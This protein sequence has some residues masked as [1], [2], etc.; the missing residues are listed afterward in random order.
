LWAGYLGFLPLLR[1]RPQL[2]WPLLPLLVAMTYVNFCSGDWW[3]GGSF[4]NRR[5][6]SLLPLLALGFAASIDWARERVAMRPE[7]VLVL[8]AVPLVT[9][10]VLLA[11]QLRRGFLPRD[12]T[13]AFPRLVTG[14]AQLFADGFGSPQT[15]P[16]S[17]IFAWRHG[18]SPGRYDLVVG[19]YLFYRQNNMQGHVGLGAARDR[20]LLGEGWGPVE[21]VDGREA[22]RV[23]GRARLLAPLD[24]AEDLEL[25][26]RATAPA[27]GSEVR[28]LVNGG[29][30]DRFFAREGWNDHHLQA[31]ARFWRRELNEVVFDAGVGQP[32]IET[33]DFARR[34]TP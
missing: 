25:R 12:E 31:G 10:N 21:S 17:W 3:A 29:E 13:V 4:S 5:F 23:L 34:A 14:A 32:A 26:V 6:D 28:L 24:V 19:R 15:W 30:A 27:P 18:L 33:V 9:W 16:A 2:A 11:E 8:L 7:I 1:R 22:R 20:P